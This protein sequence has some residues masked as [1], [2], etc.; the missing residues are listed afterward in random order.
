MIDFLNHDYYLKRFHHLI[1]FIL[2]C[3]PRIIHFEIKSI[4]RNPH[5]IGTFTKSF[6][7]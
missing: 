7:L 6:I 1:L 5:K 2:S 3:V 4:E